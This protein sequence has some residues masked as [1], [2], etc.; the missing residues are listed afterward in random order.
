LTATAFDQHET[1]N[2]AGCAGFALQPNVV[3]TPRVPKRHKVAVQGIL[4]EAIAF[5][6]KDLGAQGIL[7]NAAR[8][9]ELDRL[10]S[11]FDGR[12]F[13]LL[14]NRLGSFKNRFL[15]GYGLWLRRFGFRLLGRAGT[16]SNG[17]CCFFSCGLAGAA[18]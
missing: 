5:L 14:G 16:A 10:N 2:P 6:G 12:G 17:L 3:E 13:G 4:V 1:D 11:V 15:A 8:A 9:A 18:G 7:R